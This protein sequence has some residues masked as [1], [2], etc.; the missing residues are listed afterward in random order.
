M[1]NENMSFAQRSQKRIHFDHKDMDYFLP[2]I[3]GREIYDG[4]DRQECL[5][6]VW[7]MVFPRLALVLRF[8]R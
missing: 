8:G 5:S 7:R 4:S 3:L 1:G 2:W 6:T